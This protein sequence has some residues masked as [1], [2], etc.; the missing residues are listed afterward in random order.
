MIELEE[1][2][3][4]DTTLRREHVLFEVESPHFL[5]REHRTL[6]C[7]ELFDDRR[8]HIRISIRRPRKFFNKLLPGAKFFFWRWRRLLT[9]ASAT[10]LKG[11]ARPVPRLNRPDLPGWSKNHRFTATT[12]SMNTISRCWAPAA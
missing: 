2:H 5:V 11:W 6:V 8:G 4:F 9:T 3:D 1:W 7:L 10:S 12:S